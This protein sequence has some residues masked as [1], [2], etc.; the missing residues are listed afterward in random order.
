MTSID[1]SLSLN[2]YNGSLSISG[3]SGYDYSSLIEAQYEA[4]LAPA[5]TLETKVEQ[6]ELE[7]AAY[8]EM[9]GLLGDLQSA[10]EVLTTDGGFNSTSVFD[11]KASYL[12]SSNSAVAADDVLGVS[13]TA[14]A[15]AATYEVEVNQVATAHKLSSNTLASRSDGLGYNGSFTIGLEGGAS[16]EITVTADMSL[17]DIVGEINAYSNDTGVTASVLQVSEDE[18]ALVLSADETNQNIELASTGGD[19]LMQDLGVTDGAGGYV[20]ELR[21]AQPAEFIIDGQSVTR[22]DNDIDDLLDG[23]TLSLYTAEP[24]TTLTLEVSE[25][26]SSIN[27]AVTAFV[28]AYNA[29]REFALTHQATND[30]GGASDN[31]VLFGDNT[32]RTVNSN[33]YDYLNGAVDVDGTSYSLGNFGITFDNSNN[34]EIDSEA[35]EDAL[36]YDLDAL[37]S[38]FEFGMDANSSDLSVLSHDGLYGNSD[39]TLNVTTDADGAIA[40]ADIDGVPGS[41]DI[42][43]TRLSGAEGTA[44]EGLTFVYTGDA[45]KSIDVSLAQGIADQLNYALDLWS[46]ETNGTLTTLIRDLQDE[47]EDKNDEIGDIQTDA[48]RYLDDLVEYYAE[49]EAKIL[50]ADL[51]QDQLDA[52]IDANNE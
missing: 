9:Y 33:L 14:G 35:L 12:S 43:G 50:E 3:S 36:L 28:D 26:L 25:D 29:Y 4:Y 19:D 39:F 20:N 24:G 2:D 1:S 10:A 47:I 32:L 21:A 5:Y 41:L 11:D 37:Q 18:F 8:E 7:L 27:D 31:A 34:L 45:T 6:A 15:S 42:N 48:D 13:T 16:E 46:D 30:E 51:L 40:A 49:M 52:L 44:Y 17:Q 22:D 38:F 23:I